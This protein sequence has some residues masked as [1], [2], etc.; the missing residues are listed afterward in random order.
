MEEV[1]RGCLYVGTGELVRVPVLW[2]FSVDLVFSSFGN[3]EGLLGSV[4]KT[5]PRF[6]RTHR[7]Q[8]IV[9]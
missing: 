3:I 8:D 1:P 6:G 5:C 4:P 9:L 2:V 7:T